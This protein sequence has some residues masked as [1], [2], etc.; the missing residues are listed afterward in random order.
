MDTRIKHISEVFKAYIDASNEIPGR[1]SYQTGECAG[2]E[3]CLD[4]I[5]DIFKELSPVKLCNG[6]DQYYADRR[7][8]VTYC[9]NYGNATT[10]IRCNV[11]PCEVYDQVRPSWCP[12]EDA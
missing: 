1:T 10:T 7:L 9:N 6:C 2:V 8:G 4:I 3:W 5:N 11:H 12:L